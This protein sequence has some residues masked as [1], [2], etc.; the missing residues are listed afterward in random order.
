MQLG[1]V[2]DR[3]ASEIVMS[4]RARRV[5]RERLTYLAAP[6]IV[7]LERTLKAVAASG[8][9]GDYLEFGVALGGASILI[10]GAARR[11][12]RTF[13]GYDVFGMIPP[14]T[15]EHDDRK[16]L[17]R[18]QVIA[19]GQSEGLG[20]DLYYGYRTDLV[21]EVERSFSRHG[22]AVDGRSVS[23]VQGLFEETLP[24]RPPAPIAF[25]HIDCDWYDPVRLCLDHV[26]PSLSPGG[27]VIF[28]DYHDY[29]GCKVAVD[30]FLEAHPRF[31]MHDG[32]N[33]ILSSRT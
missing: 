28:D 20:G 17:D 15:S 2:I 19:T 5:R 11:A 12:G 13:A 22:L 32:P 24:R 16:S 27:A 25:A 21:D 29:G 23:L 7:R 1:Q 8:C 18:Y 31:V 10:A 33:V 6:K 3:L 30:E 4:P 26:M 14:P 9:E